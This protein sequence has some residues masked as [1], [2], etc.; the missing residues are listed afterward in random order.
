[1]VQFWAVLA[2]LTTVHAVA[3]GQVNTYF[4]SYSVRAVSRKAD[5]LRFF[6]DG[7]GEPLS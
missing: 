5:T 1:M 7:C 3:D 2:T 6:Q 4:E